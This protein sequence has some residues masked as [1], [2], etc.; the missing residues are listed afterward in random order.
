MRMDRER[1]I[2]DVAGAMDLVTRIQWR[3]LHDM[4]HRER[5]NRHEIGAGYKVLLGVWCALLKRKVAL[6]SCA[7]ECCT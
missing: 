2:E 1:A 7:L 5:A 3:M 6:E 4:T